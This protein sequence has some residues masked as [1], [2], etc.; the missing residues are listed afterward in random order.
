MPGMHSSHRTAVMQDLM[1]THTTPENKRLKER[2][3]L[4]KLPVYLFSPSRAIT[5][6][7]SDANPYQITKYQLF[8]AE[9]RNE[10]FP[11]FPLLFPKPFLIQTLKK[12]QP[13]SHHRASNTTS[14]FPDWRGARSTGTTNHHTLTRDAISG[15]SLGTSFPLAIDDNSIWQQNQGI[16]QKNRPKCLYR[17]FT[18]HFGTSADTDFT[19]PVASPT[20][21]R[22]TDNRRDPGNQS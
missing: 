3:E 5:W 18:A 1:K 21:L 15:R 13:S 7:P 11:E 4:F 16:E 14:H 22:N 12:M 10:L 19:K 2:D 17:E 8:G 6:M 20:P 9:T